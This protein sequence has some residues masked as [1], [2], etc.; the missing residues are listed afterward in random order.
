M[1][2][3]RA[4]IIFFNRYLF[5]FLEEIFFRL[6]LDFKLFCNQLQIY[7]MFCG[8]YFGIHLLLPS[9]SILTVDMLDFEF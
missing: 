1:T 6:R 5:A 8:F 4:N 2:G 9:L 3:N 7:N